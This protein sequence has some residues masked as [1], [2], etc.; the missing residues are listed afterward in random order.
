MDERTLQVLKLIQSHSK[1]KNYLTILCYF[2]IISGI[3]V[4]VIHAMSKNNH[5]V[6]LVKQ[7][8][9]NSDNYK[10]EKIMTNPR[11]IFQHDDGQL[12]NI[13][14]KKA[15]HLDQDE[16]ILYDVF[17]TGNIGNITA[18]ELEVKDKGNHLIFTQNPVLILNRTE[19]I[20]KKTDK[21]EQ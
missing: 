20:N 1:I 11:M 12:Y 13:K 18:G 3:F 9:E 19:G 8:N 14:A 7:Y 21:N 16:V 5:V 15:H 2:A 17:A 10:I 6:K 4:Y